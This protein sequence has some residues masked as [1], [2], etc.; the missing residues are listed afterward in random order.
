[1]RLLKLDCD[2]TLNITHHRGDN[3]PPYAIL[4]HT[5]AA[6]EKEVTFSDIAEGS[7]MTK[8]GYN[9]I[10]FCGAQAARDGLQFFWV[11]TC[12]IDK[13]NSTELSEAIN[14]MFRWYSRAAKCYVYLSDVSV[15]D[16][17]TNEPYS[18]LTW[19]KTFRT[20]RWFTR[21]WTLLELIAPIS[22]DFFSRE[23][24]RLGDKKSL[25]Q[26]IHEITGITV[27]CLRGDP[28]S[29]FSVQERMLWVAGRQTTIEEDI[30]YCLLGLFD[31]YMPLIYG[32]G[33]K[34]ACRRLDEE[35]KKSL[36][37]KQFPSPSDLFP[38]SIPLK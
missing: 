33:S 20:S 13:S 31:I 10:T 16:S 24:V 23:G 6:D 7:G 8:I 1:M 27:K 17:S 2:G 38:Q 12:C 5:W 36:K 21:G 18:Q 22:L 29:S 26:Q 35:I 34:H 30:A 19:E 4:S 32:E 14:S 11:D 15:Y 3:T 28:L 37:R 9:K 25:E